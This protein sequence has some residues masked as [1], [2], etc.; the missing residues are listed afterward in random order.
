VA[1]ASGFPS[2]VSPSLA[3]V[4]DVGTNSVKLLVAKLHGREVT[5]LTETSEQT[6]LGAG[7]YE[8]HR[9]EPAR[10]EH[11]AQ[12]C[13]RFAAQARSLGATRLRVI[14]T[15]AARDAENR[16]DLIAALNA[17]TGVPTEVISGEKEADWGFAGV[18]TRAELNGRDLWVMDVGGGSSEFILG[19]A[20]DGRPAF[21][22]SFQLGSVRLLERF[23]PSDPPLP[24]ELTQLRNWLD[25]FLV[26]QVQSALDAAQLKP[27]NRLA[28]G[29][30]GTTAILAQIHHG[31]AHFDRERIEA[32]VFPAPTLTALV[33]KLW[34]R[35]LAQ[36]R[37]LPGLPPERADVLLFGAAIYEA[38]LRV[39]RLPTLGISLRGLRYAALLEE[40]ACDSICSDR[41]GNDHVGLA[42]R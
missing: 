3:A 21:R 18:T 40:S 20:G 31:T 29:I 13:R 38:A 15:S 12:V 26:T 9:L 25:A 7:F 24:E 37:L 42:G 33:E 2:P 27:A 36:R 32:T 19:R 30:G 8:T 10:I 5:P 23:R 34:G 4:I 1:L 35:S 11:T 22:Q 16:Q 6:R 41:A 14:A 28:L 39:F 17:A